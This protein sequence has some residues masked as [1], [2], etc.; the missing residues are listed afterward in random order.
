MKRYVKHGFFVCILGLAAALLPLSGCGGGEAEEFS[1]DFTR[2]ITSAGMRM[3]VTYD[4]PDQTSCSACSSSGN[5]DCSGC[6]EVD[7]EG[8]EQESDDGGDP[9]PMTDSS[10]SDECTVEL[11]LMPG[12]SCSYDDGQ[13][14]FTINNDGGSLCCIG[15]GLCAGGRLTANNVVV[16][17]NEEGNCV[18]ERLP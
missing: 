18:I 15:A 2:S 17:R 7:R 11:E 14:R 6:R 4:C 12:E 3:S 10:D 13:N 5:S 8:D 1:C 9:D 16:M